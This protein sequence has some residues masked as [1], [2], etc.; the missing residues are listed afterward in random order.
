MGELTLTA[1]VAG[2]TGKGR[3]TADDV[4]LLRGE[5]FRD[6]IVTRA[7][8]E[9][10]F[11]L[12]ASCHD[13]SADWPRFFVEAVTD[14]IVHQEKPHGYISEDNADWLVRAI[15]RDGIVDTAVEME[16]LVTVLEKAKSSPERL[17]AYA[18][19]Q[20]ALA[21]IDG[22]GPLAGS[23]TA[24][25]RHRRASTKSI[26]CAAFSTHSAA[27]ATSPYPGG[28]RDPV[29][30]QRQHLRRNE[31]PVVERAIRQGG[32]Q[33]RPGLVRLRT[34]EPQRGIASRR[35]LRQCRR[36]Y[37]RLLRPHGFGR[38]HRHP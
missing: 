17:S 34:A 36:Q 1:P 38:R 13:Q 29:P 25:R 4:Q 31:P 26:C 19:E 11:A 23:R 20:V 37:R 15:S 35:L 5:V 10:L 9:S 33:F 16:L 12:H 32:R 18:L 21:V 28:S 6:G 30:H 14:Y 7:E 22:E 8:A 27:T 24:V 3:I 2:L